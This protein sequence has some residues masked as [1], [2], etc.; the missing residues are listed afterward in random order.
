MSV[1]FE[2]S[3]LFPASPQVVYDTWLDSAGHAAMTGFPASIK[4][5]TGNEFVVGDG[6]ITGMN[7]EL[8]PGKLIRQSWRTQEFDESDDDSE[9]TITLELEETGTRLTLKHTNLPDHGMQYK[10][11]WVE[12]YFEP[13][14]AYFLSP[15]S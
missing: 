3:D 14:K 12:H 15:A 5:E 11:G 9:L 8:I 6:Y 10:D 13:M 2:I 1:E 4:G 7:L